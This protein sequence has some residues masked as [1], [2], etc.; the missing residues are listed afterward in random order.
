MAYFQD[1]LLS[2]SS[3][4]ENTIVLTKIKKNND[5]DLIHLQETRLLV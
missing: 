5:N 3:G 2:L 1:V 4:Y